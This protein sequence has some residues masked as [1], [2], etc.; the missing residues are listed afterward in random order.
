MD[1]ALS[2]ISDIRIESD[3]Y[4]DKDMC[5]WYAMQDPVAGTERCC[6]PE[7]GYFGEITTFSARDSV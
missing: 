6:F 7:V 3:I 5:G 2:S 4:V 1:S